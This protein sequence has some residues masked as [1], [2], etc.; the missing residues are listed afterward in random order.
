MGLDCIVDIFLYKNNLVG[1]RWILGTL[2]DTEYI[3][4]GSEPRDFPSV[5]LSRIVGYPGQSRASTDG[6]NHLDLLH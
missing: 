2:T 5:V 3:M 6:M 1:K 4:T